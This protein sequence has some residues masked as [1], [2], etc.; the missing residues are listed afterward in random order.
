MSLMHRERV[1]VQRTV[2]FSDGSKRT[3]RMEHGHCQN[4]DGLCPDPKASPWNLPLV[5]VYLQNGTEAPGK[6]GYGLEKPC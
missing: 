3:P 4:S 6:N 5:S 1:E 2:N